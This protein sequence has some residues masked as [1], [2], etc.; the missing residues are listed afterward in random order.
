MVHQNKP[1]AASGKLHSVCGVA[2]L[3]I[4]QIG[5]DRRTDYAPK[6]QAWPPRQFVRRLFYLHHFVI[7][8]LLRF[9]FHKCASAK[10]FYCFTLYYKMRRRA[11]EQGDYILRLKKHI[12]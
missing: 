2:E 11:T 6:K 7:G 3:S 10:K 12:N 4:A 5:R 1:W 9:N 8:K